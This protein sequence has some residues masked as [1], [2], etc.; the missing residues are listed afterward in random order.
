MP[1]TRNMVLVEQARTMAAE[2]KTQREAAEAL[3][4][5]LRTIQSW[6]VDWPMGRPKVTEEAASERTL[7]RRRAASPE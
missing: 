7:R 2:G 3:G 5:P 4:V 1:R 6:P